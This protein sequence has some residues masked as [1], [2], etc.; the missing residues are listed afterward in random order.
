MGDALADADAV[1]RRAYSSLIL[2]DVARQ[3]DGFLRVLCGA[4]H[5]GAEGEDSRVQTV[6]IL[7]QEAREAEH[8][9]FQTPLA[10]KTA[11]KRWIVCSTPV[12]W[13]CPQWMKC[14]RCSCFF[15]PFLSELFVYPPEGEG[16]KPEDTV[17]EI[18]KEYGDDVCSKMPRLQCNHSPAGVP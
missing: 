5:R 1:R 12:R 2:D 10:L 15:S 3:F 9:C 16:Q 14:S 13:F 18:Q 6:H 4:G 7:L 8:C 11:K 17:D